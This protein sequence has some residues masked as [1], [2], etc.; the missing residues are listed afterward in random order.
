M[1]QIFHSS[2]NTTFMWNEQ[3]CRHFMH[4]AWN[5]MG[6]WSWFVYLLFHFF[7]YL[8]WGQVVS[9]QMILKVVIRWLTYVIQ[10]YVD[11]SALMVRS[12]PYH[13]SEEMLPMCYRCSTY[14]P[15]MTSTA[16][17]CTNCGQP[18]V[19]SFVSFGKSLHCLPSDQDLVRTVHSY[20]VV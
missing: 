14:N 5:F 16:N 4:I 1:Y 10:E 6:V 9:L 3:S 2:V 17:C 15:L 11:L 8:V 13:D 7:I 19:H 20:L 12:K 18:F